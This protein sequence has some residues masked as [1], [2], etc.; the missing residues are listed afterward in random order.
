MTIGNTLLE[1]S[2]TL[3]AIKSTTRILRI[4]RAATAKNCVGA[5]RST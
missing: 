4:T 3:P 5:G 1:V 2:R